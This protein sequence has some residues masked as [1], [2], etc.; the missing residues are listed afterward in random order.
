V[1]DI[2]TVRNS[3]KKPDG[4]SHLLVFKPIK[5]YP[6]SLKN[7]YKFK[8]GV[9]I[10]AYKNT[11]FVLTDGESQIYKKVQQS[12][13]NESD[14]EAKMDDMYIEKIDDFS[15]E[16]FGWGENK[17][18]MLL[19]SKE[20]RQR[21]TKLIIKCPRVKRIDVQQGHFMAYIVGTEY[22]CEES[23]S[24]EDYSDQSK[25]DIEQEKDDKV[26]ELPQVNDEN[27][28]RA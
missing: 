19:T 17:N 4:R 20:L 5:V 28:G 26:A 6:P 2:R 27:K 12:E 24:Q 21:P 7:D 3:N 15:D 13:V 8:K 16:V 9:Q 25:E 23:E 14:E 22:I 18:N 11:S 1:S 10:I